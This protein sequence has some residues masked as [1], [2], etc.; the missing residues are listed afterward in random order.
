MSGEGGGDVVVLWLTLW[1][2][3]RGTDIVVGYTYAMNGW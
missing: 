2:T 1:G 3:S